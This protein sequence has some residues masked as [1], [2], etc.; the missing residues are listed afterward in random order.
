[1]LLWI[2]T[3]VPTDDGYRAEVGEF[4]VVGPA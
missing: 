3:V 4:E 1:V 2:T